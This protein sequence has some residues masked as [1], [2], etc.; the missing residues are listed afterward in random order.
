MISFQGNDV[1]GHF[2]TDKQFCEAVF[3]VGHQA[4]CASV[5]GVSPLEVFSHECVTFSA[6]CPIEK[7]VSSVT[8]RSML[9]CFC[10]SCTFLNRKV[11]IFSW[12]QSYLA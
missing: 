2:L 5:N 12:K 9:I 1:I 7:E 4:Q 11:N 10:V 6:N 8:G 3:D